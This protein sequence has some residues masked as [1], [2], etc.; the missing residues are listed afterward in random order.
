MKI[1]LRFLFISILTSLFI[2]FFIKN[3]Q[4][5]QVLSE[6]IIGS[7][8]LFSIIFFLPIFLCHR[9]KDKDIK[10]YTLNK[11]NYDRIKNIVEKK[12]K[13]KNKK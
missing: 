10:D 11:E 12:N 13:I 5:N 6:K 7:T 9:W 2:G 1:V 8:V 3:Y 4:N